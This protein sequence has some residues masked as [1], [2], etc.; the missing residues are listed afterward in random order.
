MERSFDNIKLPIA[1]WILYFIN[2]ASTGG[3]S[4]V[5]EGK[6]LGSNPDLDIFHPEWKISFNF[7]LYPNM[8]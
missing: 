1:T 2:Q 6:V 5:H 8:Q 3:R 7:C 4:L